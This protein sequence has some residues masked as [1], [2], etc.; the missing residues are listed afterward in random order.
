[1]LTI[2][3][4]SHTA[5]DLS[6]DKRLMRVR[7]KQVLEDFKQANTMTSVSRFANAHIDFRPDITP[8]QMTGR[9]DKLPRWHKVRTFTSTIP[10]QR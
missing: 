2:M 3:K 9:M 4:K 1:M 6:N 7:S 10:D 8:P 5:E